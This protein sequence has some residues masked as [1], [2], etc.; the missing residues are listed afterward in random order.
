MHSLVTTARRLVPIAFALSALIVS[1]A[2]PSE[3]GTVSFN[4]VGSFAPC[5]TITLDV[6]VDDD[7]NDLRGFS[8]VFVFDPSIVMPISVEPGALVEGASCPNFLTWPNET[9]IGDSIWVDG[10]ALGC[11]VDGP[12][13][14]I[15]IRFVGVNDGVS[16]IECRSG[17]LRDSENQEI[18]FTC[19]Q[20]SIEAN[21]NTAT[22]PMHWGRIKALYR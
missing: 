5:D 14:F 22:E 21:C 8:F 10:V 18:P 15:Q 16:T 2:M 12:G 6:L 13:S 1:F 7:V 17:S 9:T 3:A 4:R 20:G 11:S 19:V